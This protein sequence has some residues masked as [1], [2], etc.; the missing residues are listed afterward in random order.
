MA[1]GSPQDVFDVRAFI[2]TL[3]VGQVPRSAEAAAEHRLVVQ[4][5]AVKVGLD[6]RLAPSGSWELV[7]NGEL[8]DGSE[9]TAVDSSDLIVVRQ[10]V[11]AAGL[12]QEEAAAE[13]QNYP[14]PFNPQTGISYSL[15]VAALVQLTIHNAAGQQV[16]RLVDEVQ[17]PGRYRSVW[18]GRTED[19]VAVANG[20]YLYDLRVG[21]ARWTQDAADEVGSGAGPRSGPIPCLDA[22]AHQTPSGI[23]KGHQGRRP[24]SAR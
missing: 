22:S 8:R 14:N 23:S 19:G 16:R 2:D 20:V 3:A 4:G 24:R 7:V 12:A 11:S 6:P 17:Q 1:P 13:P 18:D 15:D 9:P 10:T 21:E 5:R